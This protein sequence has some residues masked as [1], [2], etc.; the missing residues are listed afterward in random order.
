MLQVH[1]SMLKVDLGL[2]LF[3]YI[4]LSFFDYTDI[5]NTVVSAVVVVVMI[6][7]VVFS[8]RVVCFY[9]K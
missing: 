7:I 5:P 3:F 2:S 8:K 6:V 9:F 4:T 1:H